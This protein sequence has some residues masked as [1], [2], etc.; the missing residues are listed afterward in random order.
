M[1]ITL[2]INSHENETLPPKQENFLIVESYGSVYME[3]TH[4]RR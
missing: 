3:F 2:H 4:E 1:L